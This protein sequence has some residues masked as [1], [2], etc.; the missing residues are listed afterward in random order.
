M[1]KVYKYNNQKRRIQIFMNNNLKKVKR[2]IQIL[3]NIILRMN[4]NKRK[5][6]KMINQK[7]NQKLKKYDKNMNNVYKR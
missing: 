7:L 5:N 1:N 3:M 6:K 4:N 2:L